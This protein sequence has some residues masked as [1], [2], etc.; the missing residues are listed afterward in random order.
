MQQGAGP[1][2]HDRTDSAIRVALMIAAFAPFVATL[3]FGY[4]YDDTAIILHNSV[5]N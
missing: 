4:V 2:I 1:R 3:L 5:L